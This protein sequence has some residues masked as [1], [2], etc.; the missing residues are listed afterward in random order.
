MLTC[1]MMHRKGHALLHEFPSNIFQSNRI[2]GAIAH[3]LEDFNSNSTPSDAG[4][5][6]RSAATIISTEFKT[7]EEEFMAFVN[8]LASVDDNWLFWVRFLLE[9]LVSYI[10]RNTYKKL[11]FT[12]GR[13]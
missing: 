9:D 2:V 5:K 8:H 4:N 10:H 6:I 1:F 7:I 13:N 3:I 12:Y 11:G